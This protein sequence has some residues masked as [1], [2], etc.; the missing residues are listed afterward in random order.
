METDDR[1]TSQRLSASL[2]GQIETSE[3]KQTIAIT[4]DVSAGGFLMF[5]RRTLAVGDMVKLTVVL[6]EKE[7][8]VT[9]RVLRQER[10]APGESTVWRTTVAIA[11]DDPAQ[12]QTLL[13]VLSP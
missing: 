10:L 13:S 2:P 1:R 6:H 5:S 11:V 7:H 3:G 8:H 9:G 4:R 12:M